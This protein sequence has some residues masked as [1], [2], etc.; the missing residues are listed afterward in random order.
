M[1]ARTWLLF[2]LLVLAPLAVLTPSPASAGAPDRPPVVNAGDDQTVDESDSFCSANGATNA[3]PCS[4]VTI[5]AREGVYTYDPDGQTIKY[6]FRSSPIPN[7]PKNSCDADPAGGPPGGGVPCF[8]IGDGTTVI[9]P[10]NQP[11]FRAGQ[12]TIQSFNC[13]RPPGSP[14]GTSPDVKIVAGDPGVFTFVVPSLP[15]GQYTDCKYS[16]DMLVWDSQPHPTQPT[17]PL[18]QYVAGVDDYTLAMDTIVITVRHIA[19]TPQDTFSG[20]LPL[21]CTKPYADP[22]KKCIPTSFTDIVTDHGQY[23][24]FV[25]GGIGQPVRDDRETRAAQVLLNM[26]GTHKILVPLTVKIITQPFKDTPHQDELA[27]WIG[28]IPVDQPSL[29][30]GVYN[31]DTLLYDGLGGVSIH[32]G[33]DDTRGQLEVASSEG[34]NDVPNYPCPPDIPVLQ[35]A[36]PASSS[37]GQGNGPCIVLSTSAPAT[38][39]PNRCFEGFTTVAP[40][41]LGHGE[42]LR[43][44]VIWGFPLIP[45]D[46]PLLPIYDH[47]LL[48]WK[49]TYQSCIRGGNFTGLGP[50]VELKNPYFMNLDTLFSGNQEVALR[51]YDRIGSVVKT[52]VVPLTTDIGRPKF[53]AEVP[54]ITY[55]G[56]P[57][58]MTVYVQDQISTRVTLHINKFYNITLENHH[59]NP[60]RSLDAALIAGLPAYDATGTETTLPRTQEMIWY[61]VDGKHDLSAPCDY[62]YDQNGDGLLDH[63]YRVADHR[64]RQLLA[65]GDS[66]NSVNDYIV[67]A[68]DNGLI[69]FGETKILGD[70]SPVLKVKNAGK[71]IDAFA[72]RPYLQYFLND[73]VTQVFVFNL[74]RY[75][76]DR[77]AY[78][79]T[80]QDLVFNRFADG[81]YNVTY[82]GGYYESF[83]TGSFETRHAAVDAKITSIQTTA[84]PYLAGDAVEVEVTATQV[85]NLDPSPVVPLHLVLSD[86]GSSE[87][88]NPA[89]DDLRQCLRIC[90]SD[91]D[92]GCAGVPTANGVPYSNTF[93]RPLP[94]LTAANIDPYGYRLTPGFAPPDVAA[95]ALSPYPPGT[96]SVQAE[97][98][99]NEFID[100]TN[101]Q[102]NNDTTTFEVFLGEVVIGA[103]PAGSSPQGKVFYIRTNSNRLPSLG[104]GAVEL[105][106][107][108]GG[109]LATHPLKL[110]Q[111][112]TPR[113][114]FKYMDANGD[115]KTAYWE[116]QTRYSRTFG[117]D[118]SKLTDAE[119]VIDVTATPPRDPQCRPITVI[120]P[121]SAPPAVGK[122]SPGPEL[123]LVVLGIALIAILRRRKA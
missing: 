7:D 105:N 87:C 107:T 17:P 8:P 48:A 111:T 123:L 72:D 82:P 15:E 5:D 3:P 10:T 30:V 120:T 13:Q 85:S 119:K 53:V 104:D 16:I 71:C 75:A 68:N 117:K 35:G 4:V 59:L 77:T 92:V 116:P 113:Y 45:L 67:D 66:G 83:L 38:F 79:F 31:I 96:H 100:D 110:N 44:Q 25:Y 112:G 61:D 73:D 65:N 55:Q 86:P 84:G 23:L 91:N 29:I 95:V 36:V 43:P 50:E 106:A 33:N 28:E 122:K 93:L 37:A 60:D 57:F 76:L 52:V 11:F 64:V 118:C 39:T 14:A 26:S 41:V 1:N 90:P 102:N 19:S 80:I 89:S 12:G 56:I 2:A 42:T 94:G 6:T 101:P 78:Q 103:L 69:D 20:V 51:A 46:P 47:G 115:E 108:G 74:T 62:L 27:L 24:E 54:A 9:D 18:G 109:V 114:E 121:S 49:L 88:R 63:F 58:Q 97:V 70:P 81:S 40:M 34:P 99:M 32:Q 98:Y 22:N 21:L